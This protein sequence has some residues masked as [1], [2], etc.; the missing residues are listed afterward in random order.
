MEIAVELQSE[1]NSA[2]CQMLVGY[3]S[4]S[5]GLKEKE[6]TKIEFKKP[7]LIIIRQ[8]NKI[9]KTEY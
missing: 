5:G 2:S 1:D 3:I 9:K 7:G 4:S 6:S 8:T